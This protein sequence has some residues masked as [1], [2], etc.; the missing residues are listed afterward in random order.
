VVVKATP[1][2]GFHPVESCVGFQRQKVFRA[3]SL[4]LSFPVVAAISNF[5][6]FNLLATFIS[7]TLSWKPKW[8][9]DPNLNQILDKLP[10]PG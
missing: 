5:Y 9:V 8:L 3:L 7:S 2:W 4:M 6:S 1:V 10:I